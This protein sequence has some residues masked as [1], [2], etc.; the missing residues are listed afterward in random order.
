M[1]IT[2]MVNID[3]A[4]MTGTLLRSHMAK[5]LVNYAVKLMYQKPDLTRKCVF[6]DMQN[7]SVEIQ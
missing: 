4:H 5:M 3:Q 7:S 2:T 6:S 1:G